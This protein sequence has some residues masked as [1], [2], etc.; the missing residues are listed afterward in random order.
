M[1]SY[2]EFSTFL[3]NTPQEQ[4]FCA[5]REYKPEVYSSILTGVQD[6]K[7]AYPNLQ[8]IV[9]IYGDYGDKGCPKKI[10]SFEDFSSFKEF[11]V[12]TNVAHQQH[13]QNWKTSTITVV[14]YR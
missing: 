14:G 13:N 4:M 3:I 10:T 11:A 6:K 8:T 12:F 1:Y 7:Q 2:K 9:T 5:L